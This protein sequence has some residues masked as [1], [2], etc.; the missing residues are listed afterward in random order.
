MKRIQIHIHDE[1][2]DILDSVVALTGLSRA[3][4]IRSAIDSYVSTREDVNSEAQVVPVKHIKSFKNIN[5]FI[6][7]LIN[8]KQYRYKKELIDELEKNKGIGNF[9][10]HNS[11]QIGMSTFFN[12][13]SLAKCI[14]NKNFKALLVSTKLM[15]VKE[16]MRSILNILEKINEEVDLGYTYKSQTIYFENG[17]EIHFASYQ[18]IGNLYGNEF[19]LIHL[20]DAAFYTDLENT[21]KIAN[22]MINWGNVVVSSCDKC[23]ASEFLE[24]CINSI[25][26]RNNF[27][28]IEYDYREVPDRDSKWVFDQISAFGAKHFIVEYA[29]RGGLL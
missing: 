15:T 24:I 13:Y 17:S 11:R 2:D 9:I 18:T 7:S 25:K 12:D 29:C 27:K 4:I 16:R 23:R 20:D 8:R 3:E 1:Q 28:Y 5:E 19:S 22:S 14:M 21:M 10:I 6:E 26:G